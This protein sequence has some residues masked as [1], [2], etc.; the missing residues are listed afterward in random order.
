METGGN[1]LDTK[2]RRFGAQTTIGKVY[3]KI[4]A[5][6]LTYHLEVKGRLSDKQFGFRKGRG[7]IEAIDKAVESLKNAKTESKHAIMV[8]LDIKNAF[9]SA[10]YPTLVQLLARSGCPGDLGRAI[11]DFLQNRSVTSEGVTVMT[12]R[13]CPQGSCLGPIL[14]LLNMEEWF[15]RMDEV[16]AGEDV[17]VEVQAFADD[18][19][20]L[21]S[22]SS[23]AKLEAAWDKTWAAC[24]LWAS[25]HKLEYAPE[26]TTDIFVPAIS[27]LVSFGQNRKTL[28]RKNPKLRM[29]NGNIR[30]EEAVKYLGV[31]ID[32]GLLWVEHARYV[33]NKLDRV[34]RC[35]ERR[36]YCIAVPQL[37]LHAV[38]HR[39]S[40]F[41]LECFFFNESLNSH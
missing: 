30:I 28:V 16:R 12:S 24:Q 14:W 19:L 33:A 35:A 26:K 4:L 1:R 22:A 39:L 21:I 7:T 2:T 29:G 20:V 15:A 31:V 36:D 11:A 41:S 37:V 38:P 27:G 10:W 13:S 3:D 25:A 6:R 17:T 5:T 34:A 8:A 9:N 40:V 32:R 18:Q 23:L